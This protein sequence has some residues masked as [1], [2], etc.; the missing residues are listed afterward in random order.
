MLDIRYIRENLEEVEARLKTRGEA[1]D[2]GQFR[3]LDRQRRE[4]L[5]EGEPLKALRN[6]V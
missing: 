4:I 5:Q 3:E 6:K 2:L 1:I